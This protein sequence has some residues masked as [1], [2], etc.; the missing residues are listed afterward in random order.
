MTLVFQPGTVLDGNIF[1]LGRLQARTK[2]QTDVL[3]E[4]LY[5]DDMGKNAI[6]RS[7]DNYDLTI[8][9]KRQRLCPNQHLENRTMNKPSLRIDKNLKL[10]T[11]SPTWESLSRAVHIDDVVTARI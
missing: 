9:T 6:S 8:S 1:N 11:N 4:L 2:V 3:D 7:C 10:L 5:A